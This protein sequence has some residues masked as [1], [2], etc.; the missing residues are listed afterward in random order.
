MPTSLPEAMA[1]IF[2]QGGILADKLPGY[3]SRPSQLRMAE[4]IGAALEQENGEGSGMLAVEAGTGTGKTLAY[5]VPAILSGRKV[6]VSTNTLNLQ[7][8]ILTKEIPFIKKHLAPRLN[9]LCIKGR[10]NYLCIYRWQQFLA[11]PQRTVLAD[12][13]D[14]QRVADWLEETETGDRSE[15]SWLADNAPLWQAITASASQC[16]GGNCPDS[17]QCFITRLRKKAGQAQL[18]VVNHH[19]FFSDLALRR[20]GHA[21]V[22]P[23]YE[24][25]IFDEAHHLEGVATRYFGTSFSQYQV[26]D[27]VKDLETA[28]QADLKGRAKEGVVQTARAL[29]KQAD[30]FSELFPKE[31]GRFA[32]L[33]FSERFPGWEEERQRMADQIKGLCNQLAKTA[34]N[35]ESWLGMQRRAEEMLAAFT[36]IT[37]AQDTSAVYWY[38]RREKTVALSASPIDIAEELQDFLY[39]QVRNVIFTSATLTT[40]NTFTYFFSRLGLP[41]DTPTLTLPTPFDYEQR[42]LLFVPGKGF[43]EPAAREFPGASQHL[44]QE[45]IMAA[46]GRTLLLFT[47]I[48]AMRSAH[49]VLLARLPFP[50]LMQGEAP[51]ARLLEQFQDQTHSVLLA[52]ASFWEGVDVVGESLSCVIIDKL[53]FE[54]PSDPVIMARMER[55]KTEGG[56]PFYDFQIPRAILTLR[57]GVGRLMRSATDRGV[58]AICDV[59]LFTKQYGKLFLKSLPPSPVCREIPAVRDFFQEDTP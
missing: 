59:R 20:F 32:L 4:A 51:K 41:A 54:V 31:R 33:Q 3:E 5:L 23:R 19:L 9:V 8:Q 35:G 14:T 46:N 47:S 28:A 1:D 17:S 27:L 48:S 2:A 36:A 49:E 39:E 52:V 30:L 56:N 45:L 29:A 24:S 7:D 34:M 11:S 53:P 26:I 25:V 21:E 42:T 37:E 40:D 13:R 55:I 38:E 43:P 22:L 12:D 15:L 44:M 10:Q 57:Q 16:L 50:V 58:L 18:L 6:V